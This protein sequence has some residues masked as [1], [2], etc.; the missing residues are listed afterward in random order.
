MDFPTPSELIANRCNGDVKKIAEELGVDS[1]E[2][3]EMD[4]LLDSVPHENGAHN[5]TACF[6]GNYPVEIDTN[7]AKEEN[8]A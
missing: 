7:A 4:D 6:S 3:L 1:L 8:E 2:Y 5:C